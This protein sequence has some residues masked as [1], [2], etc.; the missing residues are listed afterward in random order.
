VLEVDPGRD[1]LLGG[2]NRFM[3]DPNPGRFSFKFRL[4][5]APTTDDRTPKNIN[6]AKYEKH[7]LLGLNQVYY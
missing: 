1:F 2:V 3:L 5:R 6:V 7:V 4:L